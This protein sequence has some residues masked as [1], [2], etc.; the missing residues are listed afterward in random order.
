LAHVKQCEEIVDVSQ[1][2]GRIQKAKSTQN[3]ASMDPEIKIK[4][5]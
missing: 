3:H 2:M 4:T 5:Y 1:H